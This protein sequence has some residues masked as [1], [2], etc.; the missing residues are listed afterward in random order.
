VRDS[1][2][3]MTLQRLIDPLMVLLEHLNTQIATVEQEVEQQAAQEPVVA[4]LQTAPGVGAVVSAAF[5]SVI[6]DAG[7][8][9]SAHQ[10]QAYLGLV[11]S[12]NTS[13]QRRIGAITREGN[14]YLRALLIQSAWAIFRLKDRSDPLRMWAEGIAERRGKRVAVVALARRL[15]GVMW[16]LWRTG[17]VYEPARVGLASARGHLE[18]A[19]SV[20]LKAAALARAARKIRNAREPRPPEVGTGTADT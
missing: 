17:N 18:H 7:R 5:V 16:A 13:V 3:P 15:V 8:F 10:V 12:E 1:A 2:V 19:Q 6:D 20:E 14:E 11:P 9:A 4:L